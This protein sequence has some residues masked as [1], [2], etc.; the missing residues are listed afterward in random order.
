MEIAT[1][2]NVRSQENMLIRTD[3]IFKISPNILCLV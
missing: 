3:Y 1:A 2:L